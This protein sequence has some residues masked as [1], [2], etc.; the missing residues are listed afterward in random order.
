MSF[1]H[2]LAVKKENAFRL[3]MCATVQMTVL[4]LMTK[5]TAVSGLLC[6]HDEQIIMAGFLLFSSF[7]PS[8]LEGHISGVRSRDIFTG[9]EIGPS[10]NL[11]PPFQPG[12]YVMATETRLLKFSLSYTVFLESL[13][14]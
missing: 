7:P 14:L 5:P 6:N 4:T 9:W 3:E 12:E 1:Q 11:P 13:T 10:L 8:G 2:V